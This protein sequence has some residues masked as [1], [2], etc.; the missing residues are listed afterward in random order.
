MNEKILKKYGTTDHIEICI[1]E[2]AELIH[3]LSKLK[4]S[5]GIG[6]ATPTTIEQARLDVIQALADA[7]NGID[8]VMDSLNVSIEDV[9]ELIEIADKRQLRL[10]G[11]DDD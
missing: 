7:I 1:E 11:E 4:R 10:I 3:A 5:Y 9:H 2:C 6:Y 8:Y